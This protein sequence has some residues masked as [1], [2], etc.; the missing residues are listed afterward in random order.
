MSPTLPP[1]KLPYIQQDLGIYTY[2][3]LD[4][5]KITA[6][7]AATAASDLKYG[8]LVYFFTAFVMNGYGPYVHVSSDEM[9]QGLLVAVTPQGS[10]LQTRSSS[11]ST[12]THPASPLFARPF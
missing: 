10:P 5:L 7:L 1:T 6:S 4:G 2:D 8:D 9:Q 12:Q 3:K 11:S